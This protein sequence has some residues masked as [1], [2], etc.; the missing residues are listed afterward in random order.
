V[1]LSSLTQG[2]TSWYGT[3]FSKENKIYIGYP[4]SASTYGMLVQDLNTKGWGQLNYK[5]QIAGVTAYNNGLYGFAPASYTYQLQGLTGIDDYYN[6]SSWSHSPI[7]YSAQL[8]A[9]YNQDMAL[10]KTFDSMKGLVYCTSPYSITAGV[11]VDFDIRSAGSN[12][13][14]HQAG[15][16]YGLYQPTW[17]TGDRENVGKCCIVNLGGQAT[18]ADLPIKFV[19]FE[20]YYKE[21]GNW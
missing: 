11:A 21:G 7:S 2:V 14:S 6:G 20:V 4:D 5:N 13:Y 10:T 17:Q 1:G 3:F 15:G 12:N 8:A 19:A 9:N 16:T 18:G